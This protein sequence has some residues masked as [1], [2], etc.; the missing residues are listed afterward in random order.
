MIVQGIVIPKHLEHLPK[1]TIRNLIYLF[2][3]RT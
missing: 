1:S 2:R 3:Q